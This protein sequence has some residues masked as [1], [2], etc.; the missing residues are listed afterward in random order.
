LRKRFVEAAR[1]RIILPF[2]GRMEMHA[3]AR[4][5]AVPVF[6]SLLFMAFILVL[7]GS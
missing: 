6:E 2:L 7:A 4:S 5:F 1:K 3:S